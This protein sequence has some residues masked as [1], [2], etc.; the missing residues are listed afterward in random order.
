MTFDT[1][2]LYDTHKRKFCVGDTV[3]PARIHSRISRKSAN[4]HERNDNQEFLTV[5]EEDFLSHLISSEVI[6]CYRCSFWFPNF[7]FRFPY[8]FQGCSYKYVS[9]HVH[10]HVVSGQVKIELTF[11]SG[12]YMYIWW[13]AT[14]FQKET[15]HP[16]YLLADFKKQTV[17]IMKIQLSIIQNELYVLQTRCPQGETQLYISTVHQF[18]VDKYTC[19]LTAVVHLQ[20]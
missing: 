4:R 14:V 17:C 9:L 12:L 16:S 8:V 10:V 1:Q 5:S 19:K 6:S 13:P 2:Q 20:C 7:T 3:D 18:D 15:E 11:S